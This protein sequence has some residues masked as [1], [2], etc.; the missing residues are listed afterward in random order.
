L[1]KVLLP[2]PIA[3]H[4]DETYKALTNDKS[5]NQILKVYDKALGIWKGSVTGWFPA[6][7]GRNAMGG[8]YNNWLAGVK[9]PLRY[10]QADDIV[11]NLSKGKNLDK[12]VELG[13]KKFTYGELG[14]M[15][16]NTGVLGQPGYLDVMRQVEEVI[17]PKKGLKQILDIPKQGMEFIENRL[18]GALF[19]DRIAKGD[20]AW[21]AAKKVYRFHFD[22]A[23]EGLTTFEK[24]IMKRIIPFYTWT[25]NNVPLQISQIIEQPAKYAGTAKTLRALRGSTQNQREETEA[26]PDYMQRGF[27]IRVGTE[28]KE[29]K[30]IYGLGLP[31]QDLGELSLS[32]ILS[33]TSPFIKTPLEQATNRHLYFDTPLDEVVYAPQIA[34]KFPEPVKNWLEYTETQKSD[35]T[36]TRKVN[37]YKWHLV[38]SLLSRGLFTLDKLDDPEALGTIKLLYLTLGIK[39]KAVDIDKERYYRNKE[40]EE[41]TNKFLNLKGL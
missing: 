31:L 4:L 35:G 5:I 7:H 37:P 1:E 23:P 17:S 26:L 30:Y 2:A 39:G 32:Q 20:E 21:E 22:Y 28:G 3:E 16:R 10:T 24:Q 9:N 8:T 18:R 34:R 12:V 29:R 19:I 11:R 15:M 14:E 41:Q 38:T 36:M 13:S 25:R 6:F 27:P 33:K 40:A